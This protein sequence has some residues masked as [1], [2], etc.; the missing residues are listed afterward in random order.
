MT[1]SSLFSR[2]IFLRAVRSFSFLV[3][4][5]GGLWTTA[6]L[7][8]D[9]PANSWLHYRT[10]G[11]GLSQKLPEEVT[12]TSAAG[13]MF[14]GNNG[15][16]D[17]GV[18]ID[19]TSPS[20][21]GKSSTYYMVNFPGA[22]HQVQLGSYVSAAGG[23]NFTFN[24][25]TNYYLHHQSSDW[26]I[27]EAVYAAD[28]TLTQLAANFEWLTDDGQRA[29]QGEVRYHSNYPVRSNV[30][31]ASDAFAAS[32]SADRLTVTVNR[33]GDAAAATSVD[34]HTE[35]YG[36][37]AGRDYTAAQGTLTWAAGDGTPKT[38][39]VPLLRH[40]ATG[41]RVFFVHLDG[42]TSGDLVT[43]AATI[44]D[45]TLPPAASLPAP[46]G[47]VDSTYPVYLTNS[48]AVT[49]GQVVPAPD[50][51]VFI[52]GHFNSV[53]GQYV[54]GLVRLNPQ[55]EVDSGFQ[56]QL[57]STFSA[58]RL[59]LQPDGKLI[60]GG[61]L[62]NLP[63]MSPLYR[64]NPDGSQDAGFQAPTLNNGYILDLTLQSDGRLVVCGNFHEGDG[65]LRLNA[66]GSLDTTFARATTN[67][68][69][70][71]RFSLSQP[72]GKLLICDEFGVLMRLNS[73]ASVDDTYQG[74]TMLS[75]GQ[76]HETIAL[77]TDGKLLALTYY[78]NTQLNRFNHDGTLDP[79][80]SFDSTT[81]DKTA[82]INAVALQSDGKV[83]VGLTGAG[84]AAPHGGIVRLN[85]DG[86]VDP[87][88]QAGEKLSLGISTLAFNADGTVF[89]TGGYG[90][91]ATRTEVYTIFARLAA[92]PG[93]VEP[94]V[95]M[96][97]SA[98]SIERS[99]D[100]PVLVTFTRDGDLSTPMTVYY[101]IKGKAK[102]GMDYVALPG[103]KKI[104]AG[105]ATATI[106]IRPLAS[107][108]GRG[109]LNAKVILQAAGAY[110]V[111][112]S[113]LL[114]IKIV[115]PTR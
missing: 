95:T 105:Q 10:F 37:Q 17:G 56:A 51:S 12:I 43:A 92:F 61:A 64:L 44:T 67:T 9:A 77:Q 25:P 13:G 42:S 55:G 68:L 6:G 90:P 24:G 45:D 49:L 99:S 111:G 98:A 86:S 102:G 69:Y 93:G 11:H 113:S 78:L 62:G 82:V 74:A 41:N 83:V 85:S 19:V 80:F 32:E 97:A 115:D 48:S 79:G 52:V 72:D 23:D 15:L 75:G 2:R 71:H 70:E 8:M 30:V 66:D 7:G 53:N 34:Y 107:G 39:T 87:T 54:P 22:N 112:A 84:N 65:L 21:P 4:T 103:H 81:I 35:D 1:L 96:S 47:A 27:L 50:G 31:F 20:T 88:F 94:T 38:F 76:Y 63:E 58:A 3:C 89:L 14:F 57:P 60:V 108:L 110:Q 106:K 40:T 36:A 18:G 16:N 59:A 114:K 26:Q 33:D 91:N 101:Q 104:K 73:D 46:S 29:L 109:A 28:G 100:E 5:T